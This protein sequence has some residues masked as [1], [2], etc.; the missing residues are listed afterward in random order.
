MRRAMREKGKR[1]RKKDFNAFFL[2]PFFADRMISYSD[3][4]FNMS[5]ETAAIGEAETQEL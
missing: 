5:L 2:S 1:R 4:W 3:D